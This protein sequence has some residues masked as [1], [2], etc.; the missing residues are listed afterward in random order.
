[1]TRAGA[2]A[3]DY[4]GIF[5]IQKRH[6]MIKRTFQG[7][8]IPAVVWDNPNLKP[9]HKVVYGEV[10][11]QADEDGSCIATNAEI[12][13]HHGL[14][15]AVTGRI[16]DE[17]VRSGFLQ[18]GNEPGRRT[19]QVVLSITIDL[20]GLQPRREKTERTPAGEGPYTDRFERWWTAYGKPR[21]KR[22]AFRMWCQL[23]EKD[24]VLCELH[25]P[26][27]V[28]AHD[29]IYRK[30]PERYLKKR[31][32]EDEIVSASTP[33]SAAMD[34][35]AMLRE[36]QKSGGSTSD[37]ERVNNPEGGNPLWRKR[38]RGYGTVRVHQMGAAHSEHIG[39]DAVE[40]DNESH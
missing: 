21:G 22:D 1:M 39:K 13:S 12:G 29:P 40:E 20:D 14:S 25:T 31:A 2:G 28:T 8:W 26:L 9:A 5:F 7:A 30:D 11:S 38:R 32:F 15:P 3:S 24:K 6:T 19:F 34:Y 36:V 33:S 18:R 27:Y 35:Q 10:A 23:N 4:P 16:L 37:Y 17:L